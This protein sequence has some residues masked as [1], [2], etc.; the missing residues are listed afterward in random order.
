MLKESKA[1]IFVDPVLHTACALDIKHHCAA[2]TPGRG[3]RK[4][5]CSGWPSLTILAEAETPSE[6]SV[7]A[8]LFC[9]YSSTTDNIICGLAHAGMRPSWQNE[10]RNN[11]AE[12]KIWWKEKVELLITEIKVKPSPWPLSP[13]S[14]LEQL[15]QLSQQPPGDHWTGSVWGGTWAGVKLFL[16]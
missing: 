5:L 11:L 15:H 13:S 4:S 8:T 16:S 2:I 6:T 7:A 1:D 9:G 12:L 10:F 3:R 14:T